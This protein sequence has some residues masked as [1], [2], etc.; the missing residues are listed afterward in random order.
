MPTISGLRRRERYT[1]SSIRDFAE[2]VGIAKTNSVVDVALLEHCVRE[3]L[4]QT[5]PRVMGVIDP[6]KTGYNH[7]PGR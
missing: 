4:N 5:A 7:Y 3:E 6:L 2:A 1:P